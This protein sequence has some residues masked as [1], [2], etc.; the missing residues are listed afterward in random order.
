MSRTQKSRLLFFIILN[1][2]IFAVSLFYNFLFEE[3]LLKVFSEGCAFQN[4]FGIF[5]PGCGGSR[6]LNALL[7]FKPLKSL[8]YY[9][10][11]PYTSLLILII[12]VRLLISLIK[13]TDGRVG[14]GYKPFVVIPILI[15]ANFLVKNLFLL[16]FDIDLLEMIG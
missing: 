4:L 14:I 8:F 12:D 13:K 7:N 2:S 16:G 15:M 5:C 6:S 10:A 11:I 3:K 1:L 9:P